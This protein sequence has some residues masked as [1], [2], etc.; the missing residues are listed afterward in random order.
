[1]GRYLEIEPESKDPEHL[2]VVN[3]NNAHNPYCAYNPAYSCAVPTKED[4][5]PLA[6][7]AGEMNYHVE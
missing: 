6:I 1:V 5:L 3:L 2:Y 4:R 7:R